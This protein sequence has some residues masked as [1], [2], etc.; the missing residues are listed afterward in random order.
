M[1]QATQ[2]ET[3]LLDFDLTRKATDFSYS[4]FLLSPWG[5]HNWIMYGIIHILRHHSRGEGGSE[6]DYE[7]HFLLYNS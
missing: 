2:T 3:L 7:A 5:V 1:R 4:I 6:N